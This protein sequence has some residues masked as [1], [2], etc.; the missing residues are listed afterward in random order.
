[1]ANDINNFSDITPAG[2]DD[3]PNLK[4]S[5]QHF[6]M[7][8]IMANN[9]P[10]TAIVSGIDFLGTSYKLEEAIRK[11]GFN[12]LDFSTDMKLIQQA[13]KAMSFFKSLPEMGA[14]LSDE[15][16]ADELS[17]I[18]AEID[19]LQIVNGD[20]NSAVDEGMK[21]LNDIK[22]YVQKYF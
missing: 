9:K 2:P 4:I 8:K 16:T 5:N 7:E 14:E 10:V 17:Q 6:S 21:L 11:S 20:V 1:M 22:N 13:N 12:P 19:S 18:Q 15:I 3:D